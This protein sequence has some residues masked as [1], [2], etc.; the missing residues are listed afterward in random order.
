LVYSKRKNNKSHLPS[1]PRL[2]TSKTTEEIDEDK[3]LTD[4]D[5]Y[6]NAL[7]EFA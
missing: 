4:D 1:L 3:Q 5:I 2:L 6:E 7:N